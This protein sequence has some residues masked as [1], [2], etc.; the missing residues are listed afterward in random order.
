M[1][2][3]VNYTVL[4]FGNEVNPEISAERIKYVAV[5]IRV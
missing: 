3:S 2:I 4:D 5:S 1:F